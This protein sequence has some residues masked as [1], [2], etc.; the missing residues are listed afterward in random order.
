M[1]PPPAPL[2]WHNTSLSNVSGHFC[3]QEAVLAAAASALLLLRDVKQRMTF[4]VGGIALVL[5]AAPFLP[6]SY[7]ERMGLITGHEQ[8]QSASTRLA[9]WQWTY[10]YALENPLGGGFDSY[11][12]NKFEY[13]LPQVSENGSTTTV[14]YKD[15]VDEARAFH[16]SIFEVLGEQ[17]W[18]GLFLWVWLHAS[19]L[20]QMEKL[21]RRWRSDVD[22][23][24]YTSEVFSNQ[25]FRKY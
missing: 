17:G 2:Q 20:W 19:G 25:G 21:R 13:R 7:Y 10:E 16:S 24:F 4:I 23:R 22:D 9:V 1:P 6:T 5:M 11:R 15:V 3:I 12:G 14:E 18:I 8:D